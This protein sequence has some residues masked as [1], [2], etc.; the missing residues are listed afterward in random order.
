MAMLI[1]CFKRLFCLYIL[2]E[3]N[4]HIS[5]PVPLSH[6]LNFPCALIKINKDLKLPSDNPCTL[7]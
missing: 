5:E 2:W 6:R 4:V 3:G 7:L 1:L